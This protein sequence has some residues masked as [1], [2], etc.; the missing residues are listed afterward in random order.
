MTNPK[1]AKRE[2]W[3]QLNRRMCRLPQAAFA[4]AMKHEPHSGAPGV[5][6]DAVYRKARK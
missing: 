6:M 4:H 1:P 2:T 3:A 5:D